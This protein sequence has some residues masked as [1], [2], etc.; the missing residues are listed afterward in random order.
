MR[1]NHSFLTSAPVPRVI[2][3]MAVPTI[4]SMMVTS[5]YSLVDTYFVGQIGTAAFGGGEEKATLCT[6]AVGLSFSVVSALQAIG[7]FF[8]HGSGAY[9]SRKL[10]RADA[11]SLAEARLMS[12]AGIVGSLA[13]GVLT[14]LFC[15]LFLEQI[16]LFL[17]ATPTLFPYAKTYLRLVLLATPFILGAITLNNQMRYAGNANLAL[18]GI[19]SGAVL[20]MVLDPIL[21]FTFCLGLEGAALATVVSQVLSFVLL[22]ILHKRLPAV[23]VACKGKSGVKVLA[24]ELLAGGTPSLLRQ[25][26]AALSVLFLNRVAATFGDAAIA[27]MSIVSRICFL[28]FACIIG[29]GQGFQPLCG[30]SYGARLFKRVL[31]GF[32]FIIFIGTVFLTL[33]AL[34]GFH[35]APELIA[36]FRSDPEVVDIGTHALR[37]QLLTFP[38]LATIGHTNSML[39]TIRRPLEAN[40][41]AAAR[42]GLF[43]IPLILILPHFFG[44]AGLEA[45]QAASD[46][47]AFV[48]C[49][50]IACA[51]LRKLK[52]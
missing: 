38:L 42:S 27:A 15:L 33:A 44:I 13:F 24:V 37:W 18:F 5:L 45:C 47:C 26:L 17:G 28:V 36:L 21:I 30:Y 1:D 20:N 29:L 35:F 41:T 14:M 34:V 4:I 25:L 31:Q 46:L 51:T 22:L 2:L 3:T 39:Q 19:A 16:L 40:L 9:I 10:G 43:F 50:P 52:T 32:R 49:V 23:P 8:G 7:F 6:A 48:L 12:R 11:Q